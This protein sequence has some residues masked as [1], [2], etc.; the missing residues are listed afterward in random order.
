MKCSILLHCIWVFTVFKSTHLGVSRIQRV[1]VN[2]RKEPNMRKEPKSHELAHLLLHT[3]WMCLLVLNGSI[4]FLQE[5]EKRRNKQHNQFYQLSLICTALL[6]I[7]LIN[8]VYPSAVILI[9][10]IWHCT[11]WKTSMMLNL[12]QESIIRSYDRQ[13]KEWTNGLTEK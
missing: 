1:K 12:L 6:H 10:L 4:N 2:F 8:I 7:N 5:N 9:R 3:P 13:F 11:L